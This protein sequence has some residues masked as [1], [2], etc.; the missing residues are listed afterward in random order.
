MAKPNI[1]I[2]MADQLTASLT[3][4][5]GH[6]VVKTPNLDRL[7]RGGVR[8][9]TAYTNCPLCAPVRAVM[10][11]GQY[12]SRTRSYDNACPFPSD[13][14]T[15]AHSLR[16]A[17]YE[18]VAAGKMHFV[19]PDQ[20]HGLERRL[21]TDIY[22]SDFSWSPT[23]EDVIESMNRPLA[24]KWAESSPNT[25]SCDWSMQ[26]D[27]D[28]EVQFRALEFLRAHR[29]CDLPKREN[30]RPFCLFMSYTHPHP[31]YLA[32]RKFWDMY[33]DAEI[34]VPEIPDNLEEIRSPMDRWLHY[35][36]GI[37]DDIKQD[38]EIIRRIRRAY[39]GMVSYVDAKVGELLD[40]LE[41]MGL[42]ENTAVIF[43]SDHGDHLGER[44]LLEKRTF[45]ESSARIPLIASFP[46]QW[47]CGHVCTEPVSFVDFFPTLAEIA[48]SP[49]PE[50]IDG[51]SFVELLEGRQSSSPE[52]LAISE[53]HSE[54]VASLTF[55]VRK[56]AYK[57]IYIHGHGKQLFD[58]T[59]DPTEV[60]NLT[61]KP[62]FIEIEQALHH[63]LC[64]RFD[65]DR[66]TME[67]QRTQR[68]HVYIREAMRQG[69]KI[70]WDY[71]PFFD[72]G[73]SW[74]R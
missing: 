28:E 47:P 29:Q 65:F 62:E 2:I 10:F 49:L 43:T 44:M 40:T 61:G 32:P 31:P 68:E 26:L 58:L 34:D 63:E 33:E 21:T 35:F 52:R 42:S 23:W 70:N 30:Q 46:N 12:V 19:G 56:G 53:S 69:T 8:F 73:K 17:G 60:H 18:V 27:Y 13:T 55:M 67:V 22:P 37:P 11:S 16:F 1:L 39:Y 14:P 45:Y 41:E 9:D 36:E 64:S 51:R 3:S 59:A 74:V 50:G 5:Y 6:P 71:Q 4:T 57:Y 38:K 54:G 48:Q 72:A 66:V 20:L 25:G 15:F 7:A 24:G